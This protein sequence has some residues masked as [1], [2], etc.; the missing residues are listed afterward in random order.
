M[1]HSSTTECNT[2]YYIGRQACTRNVRIPHSPLLLALSLPPELRSGAEIN[3]HVRRF[4]LS[5]SPLVEP[6]IG[7]LSRFP[8]VRS[9]R[10]CILKSPKIL[11]TFRIESPKDRD[12]HEA[13]ERERA[14]E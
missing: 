12:R 8:L 10:G 13:R 3:T 5:L 7:T 6:A 9:L 14:G 1:I 2:V 4:S 11:P